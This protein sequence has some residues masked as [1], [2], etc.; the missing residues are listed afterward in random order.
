MFLRTIIRGTWIPRSSRESTYPFSQF[1]EP[2]VDGS[3]Q[4]LS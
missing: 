4:L 3:V 2:F 1:L